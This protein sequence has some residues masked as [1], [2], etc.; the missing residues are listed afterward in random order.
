MSE[1]TRKELL[2]IVSAELEQNAVSLLLLLERGGQVMT[3]AVR[4]LAKETGYALSQEQPEF[5]VLPYFTIDFADPDYE[6]PDAEKNIK[7]FKLS[8]GGTHRP[9][10]ISLD[11]PTAY[12]APGVSQKAVTKDLYMLQRMEEMFRSVYGE[13]PDRPFWL[14]VGLESGVLMTYPGH[15]N[16]PHMYDQRTQDWYKKAFW[17]DGSWVAQVNPITRTTVSTVSYAIR[18]PKGGF[19]GAASL[20]VPVHAMLPED[21]LEEQWQGKIKTVMVYRDPDGDA[22]GKG[23]PI[24]AQQES[25]TN[26]RHHW[27][28]GVEQEWLTFDD[29]VGY[30]V[31]LKAM[32]M[33]SS[34]VVELTYKGED[35]V[36]AFASNDV[37]SFLLI[38]PKTVVLRLPNDVADTMN[39][40]FA[41][42]RSLSLIVSG[43]MFLVTGLIAWFGSRAIT[44][45]LLSMTR[46]ARKLAGGDFSA[47]IAQKTG[48]ERDDLI[49]SFNE[50]GPQLEKLMQFQK[51]ME[52]A[53]EVQRLLLPH[54]EPCLAGYDLSGGIA[55]CDQTGGDY[56]D[57]VDALNE[58]GKGLGVV[59]GDVSGHGVPS[60]LVMAAARGQLHTLANVSLA[61][62]ER[63]QSINE[64]LSRDLFGTGRFLTMFYLRLRE[65][66]PNVKWVRAGHDPAVRFNP[67]T[68]EF[69]ELKGEGLPLGVMEE[70][71]YQSYETTLADGEVLVVATD[72]VWE[73]RNK[74]GQMFGKERMLAIVRENAH[75][76]AETIRLAIMDAV[77]DYHG[78]N[79]EDDI[80]VVVIKTAENRQIM[81]R[82]SIS[83]RMTNKDNCFKCF[84]PKVEEFG[85]AHGL[86]PKI[87]FHLTLVLDELIT[88]IISYGYADFD[89]HPIDVSISIDGDIL[90]IQVEDDSTPFNILDAPPPE[91]DVP[92]EE[93][94]KPVGG[95]GIHLVKNMVHHI[96]YKREGGKNVLTL[97]KN[98]SKT[99]CP[100]KG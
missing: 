25:K 27:M 39:S 10:K 34:G 96:D 36:C 75:K 49:E 51:D 11:H 99:H 59:L 31:L 26:G 33:Q 7:Y 20:D 81:K 95:M 24:L 64:V 48:D 86:H 23:L 78:G 22:D 18:D 56:Y 3:L 73:A 68:G 4:N 17:V 77:N 53:K 97:S 47:R 40:V 45:P 12:I 65:N 83:F 35:S 60:A 8:R 44:Q 89:E 84:Q 15:G 85:N 87:V 54:S 9:I 14:N 62:H 88:N 94:G 38:A 1:Q 76:S 63:M 82:E 80:A 92:L 29:P 52:L 6:P 21:Q 72:G 71:E 91:L 70:Y 79:Q 74:E 93:R 67:A 55:Y 90:T 50:M 46:V 42:V 41:Q 16:F 32:D 69:G 37:Y 5:G 43:V 2:H 28:S 100:L 57:F 19:L 13:L 61:P 66:D 58:T 98:I 30:E